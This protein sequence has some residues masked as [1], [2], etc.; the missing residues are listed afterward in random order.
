MSSLG[1]HEFLPLPT[2]PGKLITLHALATLLRVSEIS[3]NYLFVGHVIGK[4]IYILP[5]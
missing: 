4:Y 3:L 1:N 2:L 5:F